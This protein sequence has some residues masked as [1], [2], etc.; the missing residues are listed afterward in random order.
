MSN[1][2]PDLSAAAAASRN[3]R[4]TSTQ[5][6]Q[7]G[8]TL[9]EVL[10]TLVIIGL[11]TATAAPPMS[12]VVE[13]VSFRTQTDAVAREIRDLRIA[14]LLEQRQVTLRAAT[15]QTSTVPDTNGLSPPDP[16]DVPFAGEKPS[17]GYA[18]VILDPGWSLAGDNIVFLKTGI[19]LGGSVILTAPSGR[20]RTLDFAAPDCTAM[21]TPVR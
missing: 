8:M 4:G 1:T 20:V 14:A 9:L 15:R 12:R 13:S 11:V 19:C 2:S 21:P 7:S 16:G 3:H 10:V 5:S 18:S 6:A 17:D